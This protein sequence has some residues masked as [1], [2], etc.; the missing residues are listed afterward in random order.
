VTRILTRGRERRETWFRNYQ[1]GLII[2]ANIVYISSL[3]ILLNQS[4]MLIYDV[5]FH[6]S[7]RLFI[8]PVDSSYII[9]TTNKLEPK[10][11]RD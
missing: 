2:S 6:L 5:L 4:R 10:R 3:Q 1:Y 8:E 11:G 7:N 9:E